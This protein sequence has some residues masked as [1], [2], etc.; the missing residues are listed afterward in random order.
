MTQDLNPMPWGA[1]DRF[2]AH[3]IVKTEHDL[4]DESFL[5]KSNPQTKGHFATKKVTGVKWSGG[6]L[7]DT[8]SSDNELSTLMTRLSYKDAEIFVEPTN[9]GV[10]IHGGWKDRYEFSIT[11]ELF[12]VYDRI[13]YHI[14]SKLRSPPVQS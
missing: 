12:A 1:Q 4:P 5:A 2:Q 6:E 7:A 3:F 8:L 11:K 14:K 13:A 10:R 9:G